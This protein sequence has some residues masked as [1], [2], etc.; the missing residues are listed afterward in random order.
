MATKLTRAQKKALNK[1]AWAQGVRWNGDG[2][3]GD[4]PA[5]APEVVGP[6]LNGDSGGPQHANGFPPDDVSDL[7]PHAKP[8]KRN[9]RWQGGAGRTAR[10]GSGA[11]RVSEAPA[12]ADGRGEGV[13]LPRSVERRLQ[14][15]AQAE[16]PS[17][18]RW[19]AGT[20]AVPCRCAAFGRALVWGGRC[21]KCGH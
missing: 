19:F 2:L 17:D 20:A 14:R 16:D 6:A 1:A 15:A 12:R 10:A 3:N 5:Y 21:W 4:V 18:A 13:A 9:N 7:E 8:A 11:G